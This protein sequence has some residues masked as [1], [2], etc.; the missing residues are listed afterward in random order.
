[1]DKGR[2]SPEVKAS[3]PQFGQ[4][5]RCIYVHLRGIQHACKSAWVWFRALRGRAA[6]GLAQPYQVQAGHSLSQ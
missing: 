3:R 4:E 6:I 5:A 1:M 2:V